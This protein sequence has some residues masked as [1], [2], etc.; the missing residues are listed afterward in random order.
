MRARLQDAFISP[1]ARAPAIFLERYRITLRNR[2]AGDGG[3][4]YSTT[5]REIHELRR[6]TYIVG[7][8]K[9]RRTVIRICYAPRKAKHTAT[10]STFHFAG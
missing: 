10:I 2:A 5:T 3:S 4:L 8:R 1:S 9:A 7:T 6:R